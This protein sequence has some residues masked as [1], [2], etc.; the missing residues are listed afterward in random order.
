MAEGRRIASKKIESELEKARRLVRAAEEKE[1][2][3]AKKWFQEAAK[4]A[5]KLRLTGI[6]KPADIYDEEHER[7]LL[8]RF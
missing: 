7:R 6:L 8:K 5:R 1:R 4:K 3:A 2:R